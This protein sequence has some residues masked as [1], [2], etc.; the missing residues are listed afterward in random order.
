MK[1]DFNMHI[2]A[3]KYN[4]KVSIDSQSF[5]MEITNIAAVK[6]NPKNLWIM[7]GDEIFHDDPKKILNQVVFRGDNVVF[8]LAR[9]RKMAYKVLLEYLSVNEPEK[10]VAVKYRQSNP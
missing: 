5:L 8:V 6:H 4:N 1:G 2:F 9:W 10:V 3:L 7:V